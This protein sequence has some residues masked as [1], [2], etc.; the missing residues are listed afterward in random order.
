MEQ[1]IKAR[2]G[3]V[4]KQFQVDDIQNLPGKQL[5]HLPGQSWLKIFRQAKAANCP[6]RASN[7]SPTEI[8]AEAGMDEKYKVGPGRLPKLDL[9]PMRKE[10]DLEYKKQ[11]LK[12]YIYMNGRPT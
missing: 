1:Q 7:Q 2:L 9:K 12:A 4:L 5:W 6:A 3:V 8:P 11:L 10:D